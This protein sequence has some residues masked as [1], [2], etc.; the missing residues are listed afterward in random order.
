M[1]TFSELLRDYIERTGISDSELARSVGVRRQT[2]FRWKEGLVA[3]PR[4]RDDVLRVAKRLRL[5][6]DE[7]DG[8]LLAAGFPPENVD[9]VPVKPVSSDDVVGEQSVSE[10]LVSEQLVSEQPVSE[11]SISES[12]AGEKIDDQAISNKQYATESPS[13]PRTIWP[14]RWPRLAWIG[15]AALLVLLGVAVAPVLRATLTAE[16]EASA[17]RAAEGETLL[18]VAQ[19]VGYVE[20]SFNVAG[21]ID[22][23]LVSQIE[24]AGLADVRATAWPRTLTSASAAKTVLRETGATLIIWGEYDSGRVRVNFTL[25]EENNPTWERLLTAQ[26]DL[27]TVINVD[28]PQQVQALALITLGRLYR[29]QDD[30][31]RAIA[32]FQ[33]A[34][35]LEIGD[36]ETTAAVYAL[37]GSVHERLTPADA[38]QAVEAYSQAISL[39]PMLTLARY[40]RGTIFLNRYLA[41]P[42][43]TADLDRAIAD[44]T[45]TISMNSGYAPAY[46]N[47]GTAYYDRKEP[48]D[49]EAAIDDL[50][51]AIELDNSLFR[52]YYNRA[53][54]RIRLD[55]AGWR[56]DLTKVLALSPDFA[57]AYNALC[58][59]NALD[60]QPEQAL[61][62]CNEA[63]ARDETGASRDS[64]GIIY[65]QLGRTDEAIA[66]LEA[67]VAWL[68]TLSPE[69]YE[70]YNG[71]LV[72]GWIAS[73]EAS[74]NPF[75]EETLATLRR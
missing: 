12:V 71:P 41:Q 17:I 30:Y 54:A 51:R 69:F 44:F 14:S 21:R 63:V 36:K 3:R 72:E 57:L 38:N 49:L 11:Q 47:R 37:L 15:L 10:Q 65:A 27:P 61:P 46:L 70:S 7:R 75:D 62:H 52:A 13:E 43:D 39:N 53:L 34:L 48:G 6:D 5:S 42:G 18:L 28:V 23:A 9:F 24:A 56:D 8:L 4:H 64:R 19:F 26:D 33:R 2:I 67:Y 35:V 45:R 60:Q 55:E 58:W 16:D 22:E 68:K 25:D 20:D 29:S 59:G 73:L 66:E 1:P 31:E 32:A 74:E 40:N 50:T